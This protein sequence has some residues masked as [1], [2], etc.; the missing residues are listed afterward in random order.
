MSQRRRKRVQAGAELMRGKGFVKA[1]T[2]RRNEIYR[3][4]GRYEDGFGQYQ[5]KDGEKMILSIIRAKL[6]VSKFAVLSRV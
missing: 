4:A 5:R 3:R 2:D 6:I 1:E